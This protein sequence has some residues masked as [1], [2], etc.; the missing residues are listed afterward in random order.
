MDRI[1]APWRMDY[2]GGPKSEGCIFCQAA[3]DPEAFGVLME[4]EHGFV[5]LNAYPYNSGHALVVPYSHVPSVVG[6]SVEDLCGLMQLAQA[7][8]TAMERCMH[9]GGFNLGINVGE[10]AGAGIPDHVHLHVVPRWQGDTNFMSV[11]ADTR[12]V[13]EAL[14]AC[15]ERLAPAL[16][17]ACLGLGLK[18][19]AK[20]DAQP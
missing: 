7:T 15:A 1:W 2:V 12:V 18:T 13:P 5:M 8:M 9:P 17:D 4:G 11:V 19:K 10:V 16:A 20:E 14:Q 6:L 3:Q